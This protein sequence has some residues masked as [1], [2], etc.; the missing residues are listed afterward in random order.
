MKLKELIDI[1]YAA[2]EV[3]IYDYNDGFNCYSAYACNA[4]SIPGLYMNRVVRAIDI[5][6]PRIA[7]ILES[8]G[9]DK[10]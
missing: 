10:E 8:E 1:M 9:R 5:E 7:I 2:A 6:T 4:C 3:R